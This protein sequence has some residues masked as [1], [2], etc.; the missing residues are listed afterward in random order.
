MR[1]HVTILHDNRKRETAARRLGR[2]W[3]R[4]NKVNRVMVCVAAGLLG[5][6]VLVVAAKRQNSFVPISFEEF[7]ARQAKQDT[8]I[9]EVSPGHHDVAP[10]SSLT[11]AQKRKCWEWEVA[12]ERASNTPERIAQRKREAEAGAAEFMRQMNDARDI[13][14]G[15]KVP[16]PYPSVRGSDP[17]ELNGRDFAAP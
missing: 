7:S 13:M 6:T 4:L 9:Y 5:L 15:R 17:N 11:E 14:E 12:Y 3:A 8:V 2:F 1:D 16:R 10:W